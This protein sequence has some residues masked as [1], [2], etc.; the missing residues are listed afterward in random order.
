MPLLGFEP[1]IPVFER[2]K[3]VL[4]SDCAVTVIGT[5]L[6]GVVLNQLSTGTTLS[7]CMKTE[8]RSFNIYLFFFCSVHDCSI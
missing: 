1:T 4:A 2:A 6:R 3:I 7:L 5:R 8:Q